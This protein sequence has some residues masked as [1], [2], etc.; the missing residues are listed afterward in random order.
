VWIFTLGTWPPKKWV[1]D[2]RALFSVSRSSSFTGMLFSWNHSA[3]AV[4]TLVLPTP[5]LPPID[6]I[7][8]LSTAWIPAAGDSEVLFA[9]FI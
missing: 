2:P 6:R 7:T 8:S 3:K 5:P 1:S 9:A 4:I